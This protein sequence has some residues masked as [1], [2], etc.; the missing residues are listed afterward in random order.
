MEGY[1]KI[2]V[3]QELSKGER[4]GYDLMRDIGAFTGTRP[5]PGTMYPLLNSLLQKG[6]VKVSERDNKKVYSI[7]KRG[8]QALARL[9]DERKKILE[10]IVRLFKGIYTP[11]EIRRMRKSLAV[12]SGKKEDLAKDYDVWNE[13]KHAVVDFAGSRQYTKNRMEFR[14]ILSQASRDIKRLERR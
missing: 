13:L 11:A 6:L 8:E 1:L 5:S 2:F 3:L 9:V 14:A 4:S 7:S 10:Q 12:M